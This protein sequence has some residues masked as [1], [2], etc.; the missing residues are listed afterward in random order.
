MARAAMRR[1]SCDAMLRTTSV[2]PGCSSSRV[3]RG[4]VLDVTLCAWRGEGQD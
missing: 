4:S 3:S 1:V 2:A